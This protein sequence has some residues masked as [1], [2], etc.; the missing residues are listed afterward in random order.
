MPWGGEL[1]GLNALFF[2]VAAVGERCVTYAHRWIR[3]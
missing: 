2:S 3:V 1:R